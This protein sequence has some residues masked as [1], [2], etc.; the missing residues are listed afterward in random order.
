[1][2]SASASDL[3]AQWDEMNRASSA[4]SHRGWYQEMY[5]EFMAGK[6]VVEVGSGLGFDGIYFMR[7]GA[8]WTFCD[9]VKDNLAIVRRM[10]D[11]AG[12]SDRASYLWIEHPESLETLPG[13]FDVIW[14]NG[15]LHHA[16]FEI[17]QKEARILLGKLKPRG[18][19]VELFYPYE[20]WLRQGKLPFSEWGKYTDGER[21]PWAEWHDAERIKQRLFPA[22]T[23]TVLDYRFGGGQYGWLDL[24]ID[25]PIIADLPSSELQERL[26]TYNI[27][28]CNRKNLNGKFKPQGPAL[29]FDC[30]GKMW[31]YAAAIDLKDLAIFGRL[32]ARP[33]F[34]WAADLEVSLRAGAAGFVLT[35][36]DLN[37]FVGREVMLDAG[38]STQRLTIKTDGPELPRYLLI[39]NGAFETTSSGMLESGVIRSGT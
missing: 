15:S 20:R 7:L 39:R 22:V 38:L 27:L 32:P 11:L 18:R 9:I 24:R 4:P 34:I 3:Q 26:R 35:G 21:T 2:L 13:K 8:H 5:R 25:R 33:D 36:D 28:G 19:W 12:L 29:A 6:H 14:A 17:A 10:V 31:S 23:T 30:T 37:K 16:P 1:M